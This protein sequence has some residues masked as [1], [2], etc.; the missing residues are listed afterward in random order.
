M[1]N[2]NLNVSKPKVN[3]KTKTILKKDNLE[4][5]FPFFRKSVFNH[6]KSRSF[7][8]GVSGGP[9]SLCLAY[10][11]KLYAAEFKNKFYIFIVDHRLRKNSSNE[12]LKVKNIL[13]KKGI[14]AKIIVWKGKKP[15]KNIQSNARN[16][17][18]N[19]IFRECNKKNINYL[20]TAHHKDDQIENFLIRLTR[21]SGLAGLTSMAERFEYNKNLM[22]I[23]PLLNYYKK[24]LIQISRKVFKTFIVDPSNKNKNFLRTRIRKYRKLLDKEGFDTR[25]IVNT[26]ENLSTAKNSLEFYKNRALKQY[27]R[28]Y[29]KEKS[30]INLQLI[31]DEADEII[32]RSFT[33]ILALIGDSY[34]PPRSKKILRL[35]NNV[36]KKSYRGSTL[37][38]CIVKKSGNF[39]I[40]TRERKKKLF[41]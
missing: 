4:K 41:K 8:V 16:I 22:I 1:K 24:D 32:F 21:G 25:K 5:I 37:G 13:K 27:V 33:S 17:R 12:A 7:A 3:L 29:K 31:Y 2:K 15:K 19:L 14:N 38:N 6:V 9:D 18:Y 34:Y 30:T 35:I 20:L 36:K 40:V 39:L 10:F 23:R 28:F 26:I 11:S